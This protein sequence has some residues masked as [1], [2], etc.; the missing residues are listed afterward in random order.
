MFRCHQCP[1]TYVWPDS[2][3]R[4]MK[5]KH[6]YSHQV[7]KSS[8]Q[9]QETLS[10]FP[11]SS[12][13]ERLPSQETML[14][15]PPPRK[16]MLPVQPPLPGEHIKPVQ[17]LWK[18][19]DKSKRQEIGDAFALKH[20]FTAS[21]SGPTSCGKTYFVKSLLQNCSTAISPSPQRIIWLYKRWQPLYDVI[22]ESVLPKV[23]FIQG[24]PSNIDQDSFIHP[25]VRNLVIIDDLM[26]SSSK[27]PRINELFTE[28]SHHRNLSVIAINQNLYY[29]K[30]PTQRRNCHYLILFNNPVDKR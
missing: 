16:Q 20:P 29:E 2:L 5:N 22:Q 30:D 23:E 28:G 27:D 4:H 17:L 25:S 13:E 18:Q 19:S 21:V 7:E 10:Q 12:S 9:M 15:V 24:I 6:G 14:P 26:T 3:K 8:Q 1:S 11:S